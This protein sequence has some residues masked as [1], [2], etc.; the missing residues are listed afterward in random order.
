MKR[1]N[2]D[3]FRRKKKPVTK[4]AQG[5]CLVSPKFNTV[6]FVLSEDKDKM[7]PVLAEQGFKA[8][9]ICQLGDFL[10]ALGELS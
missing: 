10:A 1:V 6:M 5:I 3:I 4:E 2:L 9:K 8:V 7:L